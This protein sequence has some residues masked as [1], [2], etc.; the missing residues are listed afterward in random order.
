MNERGSI[1]LR[2]IPHE[3]FYYVQL[4]KKTNSPRNVK[5]LL[6]DD[7]NGDESNV[8]ADRSRGCDRED[9]NSGELSG[10]ATPPFKAST[11]LTENGSLG[12]IVAT[13]GSATDSQSLYA[14][15][16]SLSSWK[17]ASLAQFS[18]YIHMIFF[19]ITSP[20]NFT[21]A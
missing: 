16:I 15:V 18:D 2:I 19:S 9:G 5:K 20:S 10:E 12:K 6:S 3:Q 8:R 17:N 21:E 1:L 7:G 4:R 11:T 13:K 14:R